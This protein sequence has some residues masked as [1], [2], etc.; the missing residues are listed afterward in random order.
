MTEALKQ[1]R[2]NL[3]AAKLWGE[4]VER[5]IRSGQWDTG[6]LIQDELRKVERKR[7]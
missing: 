6:R 3:I 7:K 2:E 4:A 5:G 1:A